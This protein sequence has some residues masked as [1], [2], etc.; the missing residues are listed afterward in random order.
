MAGYISGYVAYNVPRNAGHA[1]TF[2]FI[3]DNLVAGGKIG[4]REYFTASR[5]RCF[6]NGDGQ[7]RHFILVNLS[8][9]ADSNLY[10]RFFINHTVILKYSKT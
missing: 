8:K 6:E 4:F 9:F 5:V 1:G 2:A 10:W 3:L 7:N